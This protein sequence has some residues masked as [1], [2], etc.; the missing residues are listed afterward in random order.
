[1]IPLLMWG[2][3]RRKRP[4]AEKKRWSERLGATIDTL[5]AD[6]APAWGNKRQSCRHRR[7]MMEKQISLLDKMGSHWPGVTE[8]SLRDNR[9]I[10]SQVSPD[11]A[12]EDDL[13]ELRERC[14]ELY[15]GN[16]VAH[17]AVEGRVANEVGT[18]ITC[19]PRVRESESI[20][21]E[22]AAAINDKLKEV[23]K[24]WSDH[25]VDKRR[26]LSLPAIQRLI[27]RTYAIYG[28]A[29][30]ILGQASFRGSIGLTID[31]IS[32]ERV[33]T[34]PEFMTD[35]QVRMG[36]RYSENDD[37]IGYYVRYTHP[38]ED[39]VRYSTDYE[40]VKRFDETGHARMIHIFDPM[41]PEQSRGIP[42]MA[43]AMNRLKD[44]DDFFE[45][46][47]IAK[48]IEAA[49]GLIFKHGE[50]GGDPYDYALGATS[51][52]PT[53]NEMKE[54]DVHPGFIH[55]TYD[56]S[57]VVTV[58][59]QRP[60]STFVPFVSSSQ[61]TI[62]GALAY[63]YELLA[64]DYKGVTFSSG[65]L[66]MLDGWMS[67]SMRQSVIIE[68]GL[69]PVYRRVVNDAVF[70]GE[71]DG[72]I[73]IVE[74]LE[75]PHIFERH[76]WTGQGKGFIDPDKEVRA[77]VRA[78]EGGIETKSTIYGEKGED[79]EDAEEQLDAEERKKTELRMD[80]EVWENEEREKRGLPP[81]KRTYTENIGGASKE[82]TDLDAETDAETE[83]ADAEEP[84]G[85]G[86]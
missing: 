41:F 18:G 14:V 32:P 39:G 17:S 23:C 1:M 65:R 44:L 74:Y 77:H 30:L 20:S 38:H 2:K 49:F 79:W 8:S 13:E 64:K 27:C 60:G 53:S 45:A 81:L 34:P 76:K 42:W 47:L 21:K 73:D 33:E 84:A 50:R 55:H 6:L 51:N 10:G 3:K 37:I 11:G 75:Q 85:A 62:S 58:D 12:I 68:Q 25:G 80:R 86:A 29:F 83:P 57:D 40:F 31:V 46:E 5:A 48:Q 7:R 26:R 36:I 63:P 43:T 52:R 9:Y 66:S 24:R 82:S 54:Q 16:T 22:R 67:F 70:I 59:P 69:Q 4:P 19:Q 71:M 28:E 56:D 15:R 72:L 61:R 78:N 35:P